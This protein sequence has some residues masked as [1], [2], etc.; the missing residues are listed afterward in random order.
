MKLS[1]LYQPRN[2]QFWLLVVLNLLST[3][4]SH[5]LSSHDLPTPITLVLALF[6]LA[7]FV[8]GIRIALNLMREPPGK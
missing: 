7:N 8:I 1:R 4:I 3:G 5:I 6:A 2:P